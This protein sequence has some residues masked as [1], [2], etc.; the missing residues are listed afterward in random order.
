MIQ[1]QDNLNK[2][3]AKLS[4]LTLEQLDRE[5]P[6][7]SEALQ[8][9]I[10]MLNQSFVDRHEVIELAMLCVL[11]GEPL[12]LLG[13]PG[14]GK[15]LLC[16]RVSE[17]LNIPSE[18]RFEYLMT[19]FTEP[20]ELFGP[21]DL[22][23]LKEGRFVRKSKG[24]LAHAQVAFLDEI[25]RANSAILNALLAL[26]NDRVYFEEGQS[27]P[28]NL[29][30]LFAASNYLPNDPSLL[31]L[32]DRFVLKVPVKNTHEYHWEQLLNYGLDVESQKVTGQKPWLQG[33][34][35]YI[36]LLKLRRF[37]NLSYVK[38]AEDPQL[39]EYFFPANVMLEFKRLITS[40]ELDLGV[41][42]SDRKLIK[43]YRLIRGL[44]LIRGRTIVQMQDL[45]L[46]RYVTQ[47]PGEQ[48]LVADYIN[49]A[50]RE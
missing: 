1:A 32:S 10:L 11:L 26:L 3:K 9:H 22:N 29:E 37:L 31:A 30:V 35:S 48:D 27:K 24:S 20:S 4:E 5:R 7:L 45:D 34:C 18:L 19:P 8:Q 38:E 42:I 14:T 33:P 16:S 47:S 2:E 36:D 44:S 21:I 50:I 49:R 15:S 6:K 25:F 40:L 41:Y 46:L 28:S 23:A 13:P 17:S 39:K 43:I 12:L